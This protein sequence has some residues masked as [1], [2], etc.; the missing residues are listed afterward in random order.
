M[1]IATIHCT[2]KILLKL[3][4]ECFEQGEIMKDSIGKRSFYTIC[5]IVNTTS[6]VKHIENTTNSTSF[7]DTHSSI[8]LLWC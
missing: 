5:K 2:S 8:L 3:T 6:D 1:A 7:T 4:A